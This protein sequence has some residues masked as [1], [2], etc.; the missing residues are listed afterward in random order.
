MELFTILIAQM[1][2]KILKTVAIVVL[3]SLPTSGQE[4]IMVC[5]DVQNVFAS[6]DGERNSIQQS[7]IQGP[8]GKRGIQGVQGRPGLPGSQGDP[9]IP[10]IVDYDRISEVI[11]EKIRQGLE[12]INS[13]IEMLRSNVTDLTERAGQRCKLDGGLPFEERCYFSPGLS[14]TY[15]LNYNEAVQKCNNRGAQVAEVHSLVHQQAIEAHFRSKISRSL[16]QLWV[17]MTYQSSERVLRFRFAKEV[18]VDQ[19]KWYPS[20]PS[21]SHDKIVIQIKKDSQS[22]YGGLFNTPATSNRQEVICEKPL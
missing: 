9:G 3:L 4:K 13:T 20:N 21:G 11:E 17:G 12:E 6:A 19:F 22:R 5:K 18:P 8:P 1:A 2:N 16:I 15:D 14:S 7:H 10:A